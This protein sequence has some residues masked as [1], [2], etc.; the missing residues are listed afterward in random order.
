MS[1]K[2]EKENSSSWKKAYSDSD[3]HSV[4]VASRA[5]QK[6]L[7]ARARRG[8]ATPEGKEQSLG[9]TQTETPGSLE[10]SEEN[11]AQVWEDWKEGE[12][13]RNKMSIFHRTIVWTLRKFIAEKQQETTASGFTPVSL[14]WSLRL[15]GY[16]VHMC[17]FTKPSSQSLKKKKCCL[18]W[19]ILTSA[20]GHRQL[21]INSM[22]P[23]LL[24]GLLHPFMTTIYC[25]LMATSMIMCKNI[26]NV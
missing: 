22:E 23:A 18:V 11:G 5:C 14:N 2:N 6:A 16:T 13:T 15:M 8:R 21:G 9:F 24:A 26:Y 25:L 3:N 1:E 12:R 19:W 4:T 17:R 20:E 10:R 7:Y